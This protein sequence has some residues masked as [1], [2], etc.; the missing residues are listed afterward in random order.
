[1]CFRGGP[2][3]FLPGELLRELGAIAQ[4]DE[5]YVFSDCGQSRAAHIVSL[6]CQLPPYEAAQ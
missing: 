2:E 4:L 5:R 6:V 1:M 3:W